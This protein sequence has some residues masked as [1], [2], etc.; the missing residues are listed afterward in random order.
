M[1]HTLS[2][3]L[4]LCLVAPLAWGQATIGGCPVFPA[5]NIWNT[6]IDHLPAAANST[7][8]VNTIG[9]SKYVHPDFSGGY[10]NGAQGGIPFVLVSGSQ[11]KYPATFQYQSESDPGP[12]AIP[13]NV[14]IEG[15][16]ASAGDRHVIAID[17]TNCRLYEM[18][19]AYPQSAS[20]SA[21]SGAIFDLRSNTLRPSGWGSA[22]AAGL[23]IMPGLVTYEEVAAGEIKH[24]IRFTAPQTKREFVWPARHYASSLTGTQYPRMGERFRLKANYDISSF[25]AEVQVILR[26]M[27][28]YGIILA[29]NGSSWFITGKPD[30]RWNDD[31]LH[32]LHRVLGSAFEAVDG[33][34][35]MVNVN[36]GEAKQT[37]MAVA[38][39]PA[40]VVMYAGRTQQFTAT[41][42]NAAN[43]AVKWSV[44]GVV[45]G[46]A[47][48]GFIDANGLYVA[49]TALPSPPAVV[50]TAT[51]V[52]TPA[53]SA[54]STVTVTLLPN[55]TSL[56]PSPITTASFTLTATGVG[57]RSGAVLSFKGANLATTWL[58][59]TQVRATGTASAS[60]TSVPV[61]VR[62]PDGVASNTAYVNVTL[63]APPPPP[64]PVVI[65]VVVSPASASVGA[66]Q[67]RQFTA[68][69]T[70]T[71]NTAVVWRVNGLSGGNLTNGT[72]SATGLYR[73]PRVV[74]AANRVVTV[75]ATS[76]ADGTKA[77]SATVTI[78]K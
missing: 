18:W 69:V 44:D 68:A 65:K 67:T 21:G 77:G 52:A 12:Y 62:N 19:S 1:T 6:P 36:S 40:S 50:I 43:T 42:T 57:F 11:T 74:R 59:A 35:L 75:T 47:A 34:A 72:I 66:N 54:T 55:I 31:N 32:Q 46:S 53:K 51:T 5:N 76:V 17:T 70:G 10:W 3:L 16:S 30:N 45:G 20:W 29:D 58:S 73:A 8:L 33:T 61:V 56:S 22:D 64:P 13:L 28:K 15:G 2:S 37:G 7:T 9:A 49:P 25:P 38:V 24:A 48:R 60:Q 78:V 26:A 27:K 23:P 39:S 63:P 14:P 4:L 41:V 71:P